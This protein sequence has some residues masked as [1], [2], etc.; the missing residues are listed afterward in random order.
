[1]DECV[2]SYQ[3]NLIY[4]I[5]LQTPVKAFYESNEFVDIPTPV[6]FSY[7]VKTTFATELGKP[8]CEH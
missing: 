7:R 8:R 4:K 5:L 3:N 1:M 2:Q 6:R